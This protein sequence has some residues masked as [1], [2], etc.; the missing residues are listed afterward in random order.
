MRVIVGKEQR[1]KL[2][3]KHAVKVHAWAGISNCGAIKICI[4]DQ[5]MDA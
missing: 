2:V 5:I 3:A 1:Y 4:L